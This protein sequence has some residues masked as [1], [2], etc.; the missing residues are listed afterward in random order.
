[1]SDAENIR[2]VWDT[3]ELR[4]LWARAREILE[5]PE[6]PATFRLELPDEDTRKAVGEVYGRPMWGQG[7]RI[8]VSKLDTQLREN[9]RFGLGLEQVLE[10]LHDRPID[11]RESPTA[12]RAER[13]DRVTDVLHAALA[14]QN[15]AEQPWARPWM[16]WLHQY[17]RVAESELDSVARQAAAVLARLVLDP[18]HSPRT[19]ISRAELA[20]RCGG[21]A[22]RL[23]S[24]MTLSRVVLRAAAL[25]HGV[26]APA[27]ERD[28]RRLWE[29]CGV[30]LDA[31][32][33]T[34]LCW[35]LPLVGSDEWS[36]GVR[37][38]TELG[39]PAQL[40]HLDL[41]V[42]PEHL[43]EA[44]TTVAVCENPR[45]LEAA[46]RDG[47]RHPLVCVSGHPSTIVTELLHRLGADGAAL[48]YHGDFDW[49]GLT[50]ARS[51][52]N[53]HGAGPWRMAA[54]DYRAAL[55]QASAERIDLPVLTGEPAEAPW[56]PELPELMSTAGRA[57]EEEVVLDDL[58][59]DLRTGLG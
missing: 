56:D 8:N 14:E 59:T 4:G 35:A 1:M 6:Q 19:W 33:A 58:L 57:I 31:V 21:G 28:R 52:W 5:S 10:I 2:A 13:R 38:R 18:G 43:V 41:G 11:R 51:L 26:E 17:G 54:A 16:Q 47:I 37:G 12:A 40:T 42:A 25:A 44:G 15:L 29:L 22:H 32:S 55:N 46:V 50:I 27:N 48:R 34:A 53:H 24:G 39:L 49:A 9:T 20:A 7:T 45:V 36:R 30:T 3:A 23:D